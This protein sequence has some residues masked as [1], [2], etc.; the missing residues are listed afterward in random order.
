M[1]FS[2]QSPISDYQVWKTGLEFGALAN[3]PISTHIFAQ[4]EFLVTEKGYKEQFGEGELFDELTATYWQLPVSVQ[5][6]GGSDIEYFGN[7]GAY[8]ARWQSGK[9]RSRINTGSDIIEEDYKFTENYNTEGFKDNRTDFGV[10]ASAGIIYPIAINH[11]MLDVRYN[12]GLTDVNDLQN[13]PSGYEKVTNQNIVIS[14]A[15]LFYL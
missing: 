9:Y 12:Y 13:E 2:A 11:V 5:Y 4:A 8:I 3:V 14:L 7:L 15:F 1:T 6:R 10:F